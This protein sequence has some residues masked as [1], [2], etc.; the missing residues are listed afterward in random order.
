MAAQRPNPI[1]QL[2]AL[3]LAFDGT[4]DPDLL[5]AH[6]LKLRIALYAVV[7]LVLGIGLGIVTKTDVVTSLLFAGLMAFL[8]LFVPWTRRWLSLMPIFAAIMQTFA[9]DNGFTYHNLAA[10]GFGVHFEPAVAKT[11]IWE[12]RE[13]I[14]SGTFKGH[15]LTTYIYT[16][17]HV[18]ENRI[19]R[20]ATRV[21]EVTLPKQYPHVFLAS[22]LEGF[23]KYHTNMYRHFD[24]DQRMQLEGNFERLFISYTHRRT[25]TD[26]RVIL[27]P[28]VMQTLVDTNQTFNMEILG[29]KLYLYSPDY[30]P[31]A[32][33]LAEGFTVID[34]LIKHLERL[35]KTMKFVL[36]RD[37]A[38]PYLR[39]RAGFGTVYLGGKYFNGSLAFIGLWSAWSLVRIAA[40]GTSDKTLFY[41]SL[42]ALIV[43]DAVMVA[44]L[45]V[46][47]K[48]YKNSL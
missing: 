6:S 26:A 27:A 18:F 33:N 20:A 12:K 10:P 14:V 34:A 43:G 8:G 32:E 3:G 46:F 28:N 40:Q 39:S 31:T 48:K 13:Q 41:G 29:N 7:A 11:G 47:R 1:Q 45:L 15:E 24:D 37:G 22:R 25:N 30:L 17:R 42:I 44:V 21:Y 5:P 2:K 9:R 16:T 23:T 38:Y 35:H 4:A 19:G 36:P